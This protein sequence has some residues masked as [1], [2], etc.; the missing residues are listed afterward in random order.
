MLNHPGVADLPSVG[1]EFHTIC[2]RTCDGYFFPMSNSAS[3]AISNA[4]RTIA[5]SSCPGTEMQVFYARG[6]DDDS[7]S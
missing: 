2:V 5:N 7:A 3:R 4:T 6:M 1:G